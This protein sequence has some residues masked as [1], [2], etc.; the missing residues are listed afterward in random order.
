MMSYITREQASYIN[1]RENYYHAFPRNA[2][3]AIRVCK[4]AA[5]DDRILKTA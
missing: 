5:P 2:V 4:E 3:E 1:V